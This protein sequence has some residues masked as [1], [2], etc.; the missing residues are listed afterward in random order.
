MKKDVDVFL[1]HITE[2]ID[3]IESYTSR[4][5]K[6]AFLN[7]KKTQDAVV[8]NLEIIGEAVKNIPRS[9]RDKHPKVPW[10]EIAGFRD[11]LIHMYFEVDVDAVYGVLE[12]DLPEL[13]Q[14]IDDIRHADES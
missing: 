10:K 12:K 6:D 9:F 11:V 3:K 4:M 2:C 5:N 13:K 7:D 1:V 8:R 14:M